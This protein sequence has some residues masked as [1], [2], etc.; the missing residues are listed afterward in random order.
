MKGE[1]TLCRWTRSKNDSRPLSSVQPTSALRIASM[2]VSTSR[3]WA[4]ALRMVRREIFSRDRRT[5]A[6]PNR[7]RRWRRCPAANA[8]TD[9]THRDRRSSS[10]FL[11]A[12]S[13]PELSPI[14]ES[15]SCAT[16]RCD[17][18]DSSERRCLRH[19]TGRIGCRVHLTHGGATCSRFRL[20]RQNSTSCSAVGSDANSSVRLNVCR[21]QSR[22]TFSYSWHAR[23]KSP[24]SRYRL[25][26]PEV[27]ERERVIQIQR[28]SQRL[29]RILLALAPCR[30]HPEQQMRTRLE[31]GESST[32]S[33]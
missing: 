24:R 13:W 21:S 1:G 5:R 14:I 18:R 20:S 23:A 15:M 11:T 16:R 12:C 33:A 31:I 2:P 32:D 17:P 22:T 10:A 25:P 29:Q 28:T 9:R 4:Q 6:R 8:R 26:E 27:R 30:N 3:R 7:R 19:F